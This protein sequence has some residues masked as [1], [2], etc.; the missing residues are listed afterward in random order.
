MYTGMDG[1]TSSHYRNN[2]GR[3]SMKHILKQVVNQLWTQRRSNAWL[4]I[5]LVL[6]FVVMWFWV[7]LMWDYAMTTFQPRGIEIEGVYEVDIRVNNTL[8][9]DP[10]LSEKKEDYFRELIRQIGAYPD[11]EAVC[12]FQ[13]TPLYED[14]FV[15]QGYAN[16][17]DSSAVCAAKIRY[18][19]S[20][21]VEV[22]R[23]DLES[24]NTGGGSLYLI[25]G[26]HLSLLIWQS[27]FSA[28]GM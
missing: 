26:R 9:N 4:F 23:V 7:D 5:Q 22:F 3:I 17:Q 15:M 25:P 19:S 10:D 18:I 24:G 27:G 16:Q 28:A 1:H 20:E 14:H 8:W 21:Y 12:Y 6:I 11:V 13:G 2:S